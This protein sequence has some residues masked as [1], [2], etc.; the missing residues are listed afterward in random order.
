MQRNIK[1]CA[2]KIHRMTNGRNLTT[3]WYDDMFELIVVPRHF[4]YE[5][6]LELT[7][8]CVNGVVDI[9]NK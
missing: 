4:F 1:L 9:A 5:L 3:D 2:L 6:Q 7:D 8:Y